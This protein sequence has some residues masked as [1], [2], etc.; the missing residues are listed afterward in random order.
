MRTRILFVCMGNI[1]RSPSGEAVLRR[2]VRERGLE[3]RFEID[4]AGTHSYHVG[5]PPDA[6]SQE[7][8]LKRGMDMSGQ[9]ARQVQPEDLQNRDYVLAMDSANLEILRQM[10]ER[11]GGSARIARLLDYADSGT[12]RDVPDPYYGGDHGFEHVLDLIEA[13]C[14]G[15]LDSLSD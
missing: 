10:Q 1:C 14:N 8:A 6:R 7:A 5:A 9:R 13:G 2:L 12:E 4:S 15:L 11:S 3:D